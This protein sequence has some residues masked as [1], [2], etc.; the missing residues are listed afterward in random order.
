MLTYLTP[1]ENGYT[2]RKKKKQLIPRKSNVY[3][4]SSGIPTYDE[5]IPEKLEFAFEY[6]D[7]KHSPFIELQNKLTT[8]INEHKN[9]S[10]NFL[11]V[12]PTKIDINYD[13]GRN[14]DSLVDYYFQ[15]SQD[16]MFSLMMAKRSMQKKEGQATVGIIIP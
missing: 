12:E 14:L 16:R 9:R 10:D 11:K 6:Y 1:F 7:T 2:V 3:I 5:D 15:R 4:D 13:I 8:K